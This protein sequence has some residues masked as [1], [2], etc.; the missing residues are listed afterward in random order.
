MKTLRRL[1][2]ALLVLA[3]LGAAGW[4]FTRPKPI[5][6][7]V[8]EVGRGLVEATLSNTRAGEIEACQRTKM[9]TIVGGRIE[10]LGVKEG[11]RVEAGQ[12]LGVV[13][14][15]IHDIV[16]ELV[17]PVRGRVLGMAR[18]RVVLPGFAAF[19]LGEEASEQEV[20]NSAQRGSPGVNDED[21]AREPSDPDA[22]PLDDEQD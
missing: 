11:D 6:V 17:S 8:H 14:D 20:V 9:A 4:W 1:L 12:V 19:H 22:L 21:G 2:T 16:R 15:P 3:L 10:W 7:V 5:E 18:N 13:I